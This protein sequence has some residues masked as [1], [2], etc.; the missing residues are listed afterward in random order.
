MTY[1]FSRTI[2]KSWKVGDEI[3]VT[4]LDHDSNI[5]PWIQAAENVGARVRWAE[6]DTATGELPVSA[7]EAVLSNRTKLV[8]VTGAGNT[9]GTTLR[10]SCRRP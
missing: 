8:A 6:F 1:D 9:L 4:R 5:R 10:S 2:A 3:V 7:I